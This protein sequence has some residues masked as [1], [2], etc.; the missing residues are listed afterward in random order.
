MR[1]RGL[2]LTELWVLAFSLASPPSAP[3]QQHVD[4]GTTVSPSFWQATIGVLAMNGLPWAY[5]RYVQRWPWA[6]VGSRAWGENLRLGFGWDDNCFLDNQFSHPYHGSLYLHSARASGYDFWQSLPFVAAGS[7]S[8]ELFLE[9]VRPSLNDLISTTVGGMALGEVTFRLSSLL[10]SKH[11]GQRN[12]FSRGLGAFA[13]SPMTRTQN[14]IQQRPDDP[15][16]TAKSRAQDVGWIALGR[17]TA[18]PFVLLNY[19]YGSAY[20]EG[21][22]KPYDAFEVTVQLTADRTGVLDHL[23]IS[24]LLARQDLARSERTQLILGLYQH[25]D[26]RDLRSFETGGQS[27]SAAILYRRRLGERTELRIGTHMEALLLGA[28]SSDHGHHWRR[29]YDYGPGAGA[30]LSASLR[31]EGRDLL[32]L[33]GRFL[34]LHSLYA[35]PAN[36][37]ATHVRMGTALRL[38]RL[39]ALGADVGMA[40]RQSSYRDLPS[41]T[42]R[43]PQTR[44]YLMWPPL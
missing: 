44:A 13:L 8:W 38:G 27:L 41:V 7:A 11:G 4:R 19:E 21:A 37:L 31:R 36:H 30:R 43:V 25:Y 40:I 39:V 2:W 10:G 35:A 5:N 24:G 33:E 16:T 32:R 3:A 26:Y 42:R 23:E 17:R 6:D 12:T 14:L 9:N 1:S 22:T 15:G 34:W 20:D 28:I 29:D 18:K